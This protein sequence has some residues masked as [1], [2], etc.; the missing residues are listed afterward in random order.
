MTMEHM[1]DGMIVENILY[2]S[3]PQHRSIHDPSR[4]APA[5]PVSLRDVRKLQPEKN[6]YRYPQCRAGWGNG[7][8]T[9][10]DEHGNKIII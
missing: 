6:P 7:Q 2:Y 10:R 9:T 8:I 5:E 3:S 1:K 4:T